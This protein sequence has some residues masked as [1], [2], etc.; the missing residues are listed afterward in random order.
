MEAIWKF[1]GNHEVVRRLTFQGMPIAVETDRGQERHW[2]DKD[3]GERGT[4]KMRYPYGYFMGT[5]ASGISGDGMALDVYVGPEEKADE[6]YVVRQMKKPD[7]KEFDELKV[8]VGFESEKQARVAYLAHYNNERFLG[9]IEKYSLPEFKNKF[10]QAVSKALPPMGV[11]AAGSSPEQFVNPVGLPMGNPMMAA[12]PPAIDPET[13]DG[14]KSLLRRLGGM[15]DDELM[16]VAEEIWGPG[17][18]FID[19]LPGQAR[20]EIAGFL[21]DQR[22]LLE[23]AEEANQITAPPALPNPTPP[24]Q[25]S[26]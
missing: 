25:Q 20:A 4:T 17:Y 19:T 14:V 7:F 2:Y 11:A 13:L 21:L 1:K 5:K 15:K 9:S 23:L 10:I 3:S 18:Q 16:N 6:V 22:D 26:V 24:T 12:M 8:M